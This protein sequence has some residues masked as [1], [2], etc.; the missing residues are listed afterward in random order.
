[1]GPFTTVTLAADLNGDGRPDIVAAQGPGVGVLMN[2][3]SGNFLP[4]RAFV[5]GGSPDVAVGDVDGDGLMD[6]VV[7]DQSRG[8]FSVLLNTSCKARRLAF[9][10]STNAC[11]SPGAPLAPAPVVKVLDD[12]GNLVLCAT[13]SVTASVKAGTPGA[14]LSGTK[15]EPVISGLATFPDLRLDLPGAYRLGFTHSGNATPAAGGVHVGSGVSV[16]IA[17]PPFLCGSNPAVY[18]AGAGFSSYVWLLDGAP[19]GFSRTFTAPFLG[20]GSHTLTA[21]ASLGGC[22]GSASRAI[23]N[24]PPTASSIAPTSGSRGG[25]TPV[26]VTGTCIASGAALTLGGV[27][28]HAVTAPM[29]TF[30]QGTTPREPPGAVDVVVTNP[31]GQAATLPGAFTY[32]SGT[33]AVPLTPCRVLD[34][35]LPDGPLGG[36]VLRAN[37]SRLF[38]V[39]GACGI[40]DG[41]VAIIVNA[42]VTQPAAAGGLVLQASGISG[43]GEFLKFSAGQTRA[44]NGVLMLPLDESGAVFAFNTSAGTAHLILDV[45]G[46]FY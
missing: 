34:T 15:T 36:P 42:T 24:L 10:P 5:T 45:T 27:P 25:F 2:D 4:L 13:G 33:G 3:G 30:I 46:Y 41:A 14:V 11:S 31:D 22:E 44:N 8:V 18:D 23:S 38:K 43:T 9:L 21:F 12:G 26:Q 20:A 32:L 28:A 35:R 40:P 17:G 37:S 16:S 39:T 7:T 29:S 1:M 6:L 19:V